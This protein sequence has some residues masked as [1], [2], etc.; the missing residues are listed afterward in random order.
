MNKELAK[1]EGFV[2]KAK[3]PVTHVECAQMLF[4]TKKSLIENSILE[5]K[6]VGLNGEKDS[7]TDP[8]LGPLVMGR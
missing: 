8:R 3:L 5:V 6:A 7:V 1:E 2:E 4:T